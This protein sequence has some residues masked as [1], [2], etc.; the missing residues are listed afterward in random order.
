MCLFT[1]KIQLTLDPKYVIQ[2]VEQKITR[3]NIE[4]Y[5]GEGTVALINNRTYKSGRPYELIREELINSRGEDAV[6]YLY[7]NRFFDTIELGVYAG[8]FVFGLN[9][10]KSAKLDYSVVFYLSIELLDYKDLVSNF[11]KT[12]TKEEAHDEIKEKLN[13]LLSGA[14]GSV[15]AKFKTDESTTEDLNR[16]SYEIYQALNDMTLRTLTQMG[17]KLAS[18]NQIKF[19]PT[20]ETEERIKNIRQSLHDNTIDSLNDV[21]RQREA[22]EREKER[23]HE[24]EMSR[25]KNTRITETTKTIY[26]NINGNVEEET[27]KNKKQKRFC[28]ICGKEVLQED[29]V[30]CPSCGARL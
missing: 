7:T 11:R 26:Q 24:I 23:Q 20:E 2:R 12:L 17:L 22:E 5:I 15:I 28:R 1:Q 19:N 18:V 8:R 21:Q 14:C 6:A 29:S 10:L 27:E 4:L 16:K 30:F 3:R 25:A 13:E 9:E